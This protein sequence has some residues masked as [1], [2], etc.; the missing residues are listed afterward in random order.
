MRTQGS[1]PKNN[2]GIQRYKYI[3]TGGNIPDDGYRYL[4]SINSKRMIKFTDKSKSTSKAI[5]NQHVETA[6]HI[7]FI[8]E[9]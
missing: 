7:I 8:E 1:K 4:I 9:T 3:P 2:L 6:A 5:K